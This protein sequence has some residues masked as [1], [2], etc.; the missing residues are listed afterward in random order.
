MQVHLDLPVWAALE[1]S[2][3]PGTGCPSSQKG[4][5]TCAPRAWSLEDSLAA[6]D[7][8]ELRA[9]GMGALPV[10]QVEVHGALRAA[11]GRTPRAAVAP[12]VHRLT[13]DRT[14][15][16]TNWRFSSPLQEHQMIEHMLE[17][18]GTTLLSSSL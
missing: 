11:A 10:G 17:E 9:P 14:I 15:L 18:L 12:R 3:H 5:H 7:G 16:A 8:G 4:K 1:R 13:H 2:S 6:L